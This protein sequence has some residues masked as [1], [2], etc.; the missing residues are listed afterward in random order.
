MDILAGELL[1]AVGRLTPL[2]RELLAHLKIPGVIL[3]RGLVGTA[4]IR[5]SSDETGYEPADSGP[6]A[7][8][9]PCRIDQPFSPETPAP[10]MTAQWGSLID[11]VAWHPDRPDRWALRLGFADWLGSCEPQHLGGKCLVRRSPLSWLRGRCHGVVPL[12][13]KAEDRAR[14]LRFL[15]PLYAE[16]LEHAQELR[17]LMEQPTH[18]PGIKVG[19]ANHAEDRGRTVET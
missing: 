9:T 12:G 1:E 16:D 5:L 17:R 18:I 10:E 2:D 4:R 3:L 19:D 7:Y 8:I 6:W 11:L 14:V 15:G 13:A